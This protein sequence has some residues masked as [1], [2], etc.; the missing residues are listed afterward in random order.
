MPLSTPLL[1]AGLLASPPL[2]GTITLS[3]TDSS[4][5][6]VPDVSAGEIKLRENGEPRDVVSFERDPRPLAVT[7]LLDT[8]EP[9]G[10]TL[11]VY[12]VDPVIDFLRALPPGADATLMT[13]GTPPEVVDISDLEKTRAA[14]KA[15]VPWGKLSLFDG[16]AD[17]GRRLAERKEARRVIVVVTGA[18]PEFNDRALAYKAID[19][20]K[21]L[22]LV[23]QFGPGTP[24][25]E[26]N[27]DDLVKWTGGSYEII[28]AA[29]G[30]GAV[31]RRFQPGLEA[32]YLLS[33][34][35]DES[36]AKR[37]LQVTVARK[38]VRAQLRA[39]GVLTL[40]LR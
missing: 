5:R 14:L 30:L 23:A 28:G 22:L 6:M 18:A 32:P 27:L 7:L 37:K 39:S 16:I 9:L 35:T 1:L 19:Q 29:T 24:Y 4:G 2:L 11:R 12:L 3:I 34:A 33:Y 31:L 8:S 21:P 26:P 17:A 36:A 20:A 15:R 10:E 25:Y 38:D 13:A 40:P